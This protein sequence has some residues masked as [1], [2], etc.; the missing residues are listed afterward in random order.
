MFKG[1]VKRKEDTWKELGAKDEIAKER[2]MKV[3]KEEERK[4]K[5]TYFIAKRR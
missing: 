1:S 4:V 3:H 2:C 5:S